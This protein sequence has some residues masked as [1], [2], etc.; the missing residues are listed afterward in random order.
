VTALLIIGA[1][2]VYLVAAFATGGYIYYR[3]TV[4]PEPW[5]GVS[6]GDTTLICILG[7]A[8]W[9]IAWAFCIPGSMAMRMARRIAARG[10]ER[11]R[12]ADD[13]QEEVDRAMR[14]LP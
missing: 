13:E 2:V 12:L 10:V 1:I 14:E 7:S 3:M 9:P 8:F 6:T 11:R 5:E 4:Y